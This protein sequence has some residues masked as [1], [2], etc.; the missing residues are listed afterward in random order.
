MLIS[1]ITIL[2]S[3]H[4][5]GC[6]HALSRDYVAATLDHCRS[7]H[8]GGL[9]REMW[10][11]GTDINHVAGYGGGHGH[12]PHVMYT[13]KYGVIWIWWGDNEILR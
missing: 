7:V 11:A 8:G 3:Q 2:M 10:C 5:I 13:L 6:A 9:N 12:D 1:V 4:L